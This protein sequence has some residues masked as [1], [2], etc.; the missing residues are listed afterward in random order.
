[1]KE[2]GSIPVNG[3]RHFTFTST[4]EQASGERL[5]SVIHRGR[6]KQQEASQ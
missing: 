5:L 4:L 6:D 2:G 1:M 3:L